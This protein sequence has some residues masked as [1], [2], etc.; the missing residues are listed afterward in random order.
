M[1]GEGRAAGNQGQGTRVLAKHF[2]VNNIYIYIWEPEGISEREA[3]A[4][5]R[6]LVGSSI[7]L[8]KCKIKSCWISRI[9]KSSR[10][11]LQASK[12]A[13]ACHSV[14]SPLDSNFDLR[15]RD[16]ERGRANG[17]NLQATFARRV[18]RTNTSALISSIANLRDILTKSYVACTMPHVI[19]ENESESSG[20]GMAARRQPR[21]PPGPPPPLPTARQR[22]DNVDT[23]LNHIRQKSKE[24]LVRRASAL[25]EMRGRSAGFVDQLGKCTDRYQLFNAKCS[26]A[27][28]IRC[29]DNSYLTIYSAFSQQPASR[30]VS[31]VHSPQGQEKRLGQHL[32]QSLQR[33]RCYLALPFVGYS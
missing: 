2:S 20:G 17:S 11:H 22:I 19:S 15:S 27:W 5:L 13:D 8:L 18:A 32:A 4:Y 28:C 30:G 33:S 25:P 9:S 26:C 16:R 6:I 29:T 7:Y 14:P 1:R 12:P 24:N 23:L 21:P 31:Q 3:A 10:P